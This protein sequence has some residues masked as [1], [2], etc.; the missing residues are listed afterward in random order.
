MNLHATLTD[1]KSQ[2][3]DGKPMTASS[4]QAVI[5]ILL[6]AIVSIPLFAIGTSHLPAVSS[7]VL[8][9]QSEVARAPLEV[10]PVL[11]ASADQAGAFINSS[12]QPEPAPVPKEP[13]EIEH[14]VRD[15]E[16]L[17]GILKPYCR[18]RDYEMIARDNGL[19]DPDMIYANK[20]VL[21]FKN[22]CSNNAPSVFVQKRVSPRE[23]VRDDGASSGKHISRTEATRAPITAPAVALAASAPT[24]SASQLTAA[25]VPTIVVTLRPVERAASQVAAAPVTDV[26]TTD[27]RPLSEIYHR[28]IYRI[29]DLRKMQ[30]ARTLSPAGLAEMNR[31]QM[32]IRKATLARY[33]VKNA[34][35]LYDGNLSSVDRLRC[36]R[37]NYG[38]TIAENLK[39]YPHIS[40]S[41][42]EAVILVESGGR[43]DAISET[44]CTGVKQFTMGSAKKFN[45]A[46]RLDPYESLRAGID[47]LADNLRM[48]RNNVAK[49]TAHYNIGSVVVSQK[50]F[51]ANAFAYTRAVLSAKRLVERELQPAMNAPVNQPVPNRSHKVSRAETDRVART[52]VVLRPVSSR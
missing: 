39:R 40:Q 9:S 38:E 41:Y 50:D 42:V 24:T 29:A 20:T 36:I 7:L 52:V 4:L 13:E 48:W 5:I 43:P 51:D 15:G 17:I 30:I 28:K 33:P 25:P 47:H 37:E 19:A 49:A 45:L 11:V 1:L 3:V 12:A 27:N 18:D 10:R 8:L 6:L 16:T 23:L 46:D 21:K 2:I 32:E 22:G 44:G 14:S 26:T 35:C 34:D 31:L